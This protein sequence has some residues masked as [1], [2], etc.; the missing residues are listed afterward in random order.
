MTLLSI[1]L[2][3]A[4]LFISQELKLLL[5]METIMFYYY[6][7]ISLVLSILQCCCR[8]HGHAFYKDR[9]VCHIPKGNSFLASVRDVSS[10][11]AATVTY[12]D[13]E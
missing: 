2:N 5:T 13:T 11:I 7:M 8:K 4:Q 12:Y 6:Y 3:F 9:S 10:L 1:V